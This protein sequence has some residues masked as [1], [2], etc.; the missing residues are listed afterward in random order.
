M[1]HVK[2]TR[3]LHSAPPQGMRPER[4]YENQ[5]EAF[6]SQQK[7]LFPKICILFRSS[8]MNKKN[9][10]F[11]E[12]QQAGPFSQVSLESSCYLQHKCGSDESVKAFDEHLV[13]DNVVLLKVTELPRCVCF[14]ETMNGNEVKGS[15][16][17]ARPPALLCFPIMREENAFIAWKWSVLTKHMQIGFPELKAKLEVIFP[18]GL[19]VTPTCF[20]PEWLRRMTLVPVSTFTLPSTTEASVIPS[21]CMNKWRYDQLRFCQHYDTAP[22]LS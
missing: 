6:Y 2:W 15:P 13:S 16:G 14:L 8:H 9:I 4:E 3:A 17:K 10:W 11:W 12:K 21:T 19:N 20:F 1:G 22:L 5:S 7:L 18:A